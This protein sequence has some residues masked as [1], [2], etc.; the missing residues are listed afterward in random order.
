LASVA[1]AP[2]LAGD[3]MTVL[4]LIYADSFADTPQPFIE[5]DLNVLKQVADYLTPVLSWILDPGPPRVEEPAG[6]DKQGALK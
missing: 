5:E 6:I 2:V 1:V 4:G 3:R